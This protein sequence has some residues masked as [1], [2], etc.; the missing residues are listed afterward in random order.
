MQWPSGRPR[1]FLPQ[2]HI[3]ALKHF[4]IEPKLVLRNHQKIIRIEIDENNLTFLNADTFLDTSFKNIL[5]ELED[6]IFFPTTINYKSL[7]ERKNIPMNYFFSVLDSPEIVQK[8]KA[9]F[10][11]KNIKPQK[12]HWAICWNKICILKF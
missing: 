2:C 5:Q 9:Y 7:Y 1:E 4:N 6:P 10:E 8:K 11:K 3:N 12:T